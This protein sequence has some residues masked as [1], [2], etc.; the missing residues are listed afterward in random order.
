MAVTVGQLLWEHP[1]NAAKFTGLTTGTDKKWAKSFHPMIKL[2]VHTHIDQNHRTVD[3]NWDA[4]VPL[5]ADDDLRMSTQSFPPNVRRW[6]LEAEE[7]ITVWFH[8]E[9]SNVVLPAWS[10]TPDVLQA[11]QPKPRN[12]GPQQIPEMVDIVYALAD[13]KSN[14][15]PLAIGEM[16]RNLIAWNRWQSGNIG[17]KGLQANLSRELRG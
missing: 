2:I 6:R 3:A 15:Q 14:K 10:C 4:F 9:I 12:P 5:L 13:S 11:C 8:T 16:K 7:D 17:D 1:T